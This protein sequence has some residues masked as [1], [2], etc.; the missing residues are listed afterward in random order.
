MTVWINIDHNKD[1]NKILL[2]FTV[3]SIVIEFYRFQ[4]TKYIH[5]NFIYVNVR[6]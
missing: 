4:S 2:N 3:L 1:I 5:A 6:Y